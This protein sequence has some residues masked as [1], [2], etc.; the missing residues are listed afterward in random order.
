MLKIKQKKKTITF[1]TEL[2][3][4]EKN[5]QINHHVQLKPDNL[6]LITFNKCYH[7]NWNVNF[8]I[9]NVPE[10]ITQICFY[11]QFNLDILEYLHPGIKYISYGDAFNCQVDNLPVNLEY[12]QFGYSFNQPVNCLPQKLKKIQ[13]GSTFNQPVD[14]IPES[15]ESITL[16]EYFDY[17]V[18]NLPLNLE[19]IRFG[20]LFG[21][22][23]NSLPNNVKKIYFADSNEYFTHSIDILPTGLIELFLPFH[24]KETIKMIPISTQSL[25]ISIRYP[26]DKL[27]LLLEILG[28]KNNILKISSCYGEQKVH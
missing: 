21:H 13:F 2:T 27:D 9:T 28:N 20:K 26:K 17:P 7:L 5:A 18:D 25:R 3:G 10:N 8:V 23:I 15:I 11:P 1:L 22:S 4:D 14:M 12:I 16:G 19:Y 6:K 24:Y